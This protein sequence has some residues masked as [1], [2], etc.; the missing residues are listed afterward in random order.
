MDEGGHARVLTLRPSTKAKLNASRLEVSISVNL[1]IAEKKREWPSFVCVGKVP[2]VL[3]DIA[4]VHAGF[5]S[6]AFAGSASASQG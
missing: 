2:I 4:A 3:Y 6:D 5:C 1:P